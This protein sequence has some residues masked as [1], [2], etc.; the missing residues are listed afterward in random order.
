M[1]SDYVVRDAALIGLPLTVVV[2]LMYGFWSSRRTIII[3]S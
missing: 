1:T 2:A 3:L